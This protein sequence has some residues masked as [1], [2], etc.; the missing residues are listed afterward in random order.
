M[1]GPT[2]ALTPSATIAQRV[3]VEAGVG[4]VED[5]DP[6]LQHRHLEDL[7]ALLLAAREAVVQVA[8][9]ELARH[10]EVLHR[11]EQ[12]GAELLDRDRVLLAAVRGLALRV[13]RAAQ[14]ARHGDARDRVRVLER[15]EEAPLRPLVGPEL[16]DRLA[17]E[18][19]CRPR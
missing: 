2:S 10:L 6:R 15:E 19:G 18:A 17:V 9:R 7:D 13:D 11:R 3:D 1:S 4:L 14:E 12:L 16:H 5:R 8:L